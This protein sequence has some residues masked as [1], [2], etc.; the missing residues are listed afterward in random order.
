MQNSQIGSDARTILTPD[1]R[2]RVFISSTLTELAPERRLAR[3]AIEQ[4]HL[5]PVMFEAGARP[6]PPRALYRAYLSQSHVFVGIYGESYGWVA[7]SME[8]SG[9]EDEYVQSQGKPSLIYVK[10]PAAGREPRLHALLQ[11]VEADDRASYRTFET[12]EELAR[13]LIDDLALMMTERFEGVHARGGSRLGALAPRSLPVPAT[14]IVGRDTE[15]ERLADTLQR[16]D[17]RLV[18]LTGPGGVGKTRLALAVASKASPGFEDGTFFVDLSEV[19][20]PAEVP[21]TV[22]AA[23]GMTYERSRDLADAVIEVLAPASVLLLLDNFEQ[24]VTAAPFVGSMLA[25][26]PRVKAMATSREPLRLRGEHR[27]PVAPLELPGDEP[28]LEEVL[29]SDAV[30][31]FESRARQVTPAFTLTTE[32]AS[33]VVE[34]CAR[35]DG[36]PLAIELAAPALRVLSPEA[37]AGR[38]RD[39]LELFKGG[40]DSPE[41]QRT[42]AATLDWSYGLLD[43]RERRILAR[44]SVFTGG[45]TLE[46]AEAVCRGEDEPDV[47]ERLA[48]LIDKSLIVTQEDAAGRTR[49]RLLETVQAFAEAKGRELGVTRD[50]EQRH[51]TFFAEF[52]RVAAHGLRNESERTWYALISADHANLDA[53]TERAMNQGYPSTGYHLAMS[54][55]IYSQMTCQNADQGPLIEAAYAEDPTLP[56]DAKAWMAF[57]VGG[58]RLERRGVELSEAV[59]P[60]LESLALWRKL[61]RRLNEADTE[62]YLHAATWPDPTHLDRAVELYRELGDTWGLAWS[63]HIRGL[64]AVVLGDLET[65]REGLQEALRLAR[66]IESDYLAG[67]ALT[68]M[69][70]LALSRNDRDEARARFVEAAHLLLSVYD[71]EGLSDCLCGFAALA[72]RDGDPR[73]AAVLLGTADATRER[74]GYYYSVKTNP[75]IASIASEV[76]A[77]LGDDAYREAH[78]AG[79][80]L[81]TREAVLRAMRRFGGSGEPA[82]RAP[83]HVMM[84]RT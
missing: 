72:Q 20:D 65:A 49:F 22:A 73:E 76:G 59:P 71:R 75:M 42:L 52:S 54:T 64:G 34:I 29:A 56:D 44:L 68:A 23:I 13:L 51:L 46:A 18:T 80:S 25:A 41:R 40:V 28:S 70:F 12:P 58:L 82:A 38:L 66:S 35:L 55:W 21:A 53:A 83:G 47:L 45:F 30:R 62:V 43:D 9:L 74:I 5:I 3:A 50:A 11:R 4:L 69:G 78:A 63:Q 16:E 32:N 77:A 60:L 1:Q 81:R 39:R 84:R 14:A 67:S 26:C 17:V 79:S 6:H 19:T 15:V 48:A 2:L 27:V 7:P 61:G 37:L 33:A 24:V 31:L 10:T 36:L 8:I 57:G